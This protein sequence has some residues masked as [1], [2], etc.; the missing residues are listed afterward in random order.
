MLF[1]TLRKAHKALCLFYCG[2]WYTVW[3]LIFH[4]GDSLMCSRPLDTQNLHWGDNSWISVRFISYSLICVSLIKASKLLLILVHQ[5]NIM[6]TRLQ[7]SVIS[8]WS[9]CLQHVIWRRAELVKPWGKFVKVCCWPCGI[10]ASCFWWSLQ[11]GMGEKY[12]LG[13]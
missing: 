1:V 7:I 4:L 9:R 11:I 13:Q 5:I 2:R 3:Q 6:L 10:E 8:R 12:S